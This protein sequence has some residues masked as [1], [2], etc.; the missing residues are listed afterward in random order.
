MLLIFYKFFKCIYHIHPEKY[1]DELRIINF[2]DL[3]FFIPKATE[4]F[5]E[6]RYG[7]DWKTPN[8]KHNIGFYSSGKWKTISA[9]KNLKMSLLDFPKLDFSLQEQYSST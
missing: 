5:L 7:S 8:S 3:T 4:E 1:F 9:R 6:H 2:Y